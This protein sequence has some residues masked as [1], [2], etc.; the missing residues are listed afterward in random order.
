MKQSVWLQNY[1]KTE[2][3][4]WTIRKGK[5]KKAFAIS[6]LMTVIGFVL[7]PM[8]DRGVPFIIISC[9]LFSYGI[10]ILCGA[11]L[12]N[13]S[14][15]DYVPVTKSSVMNLLM[16]DSEVDQFD[17]EMSKEPNDEFVFNSKCSL[18]GNLDY[19]DTMFT[20][21]NYL[22]IKRVQHRKHTQYEV[23]RKQDI[24][25]IVR[26]NTILYMNKYDNTYCHAVRIY[27]SKQQVMLDL[28]IINDD[29]WNKFIEMLKTVKP[30]VKVDIQNP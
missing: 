9:G 2:R 27:N 13:K 1:E 21:E 20:T 17:N 23:I 12:V 16:S 8:M 14:I 26:S 10:L 5:V 6:A 11:A 22:V 28:R 15:K 7:M 29:F 3:E 19:I 25:S 30:D 4:I 18:F 24:S